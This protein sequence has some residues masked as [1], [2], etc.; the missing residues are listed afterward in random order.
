MGE[1]AQ[2]GVAP[3]KEATA[4]TGNERQ[5]KCRVGQEADV[6]SGRVSQ[7]TDRLRPVKYPFA[8]SR[9]GLACLSTVQ[10]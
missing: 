2:A 7:D 8:A 3:G 5:A 1:E 10:R 9:Q 6:R 4:V